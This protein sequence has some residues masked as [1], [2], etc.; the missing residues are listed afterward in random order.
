MTDTPT[1]GTVPIA[2]YIGRAIIVLAVWAFT[3]VQAPLLV[4]AAS[5][6]AVIMGFALLI[7]AVAPCA[8]DRT[9]TLRLIRGSA[10]S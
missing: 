9:T 2:V 4:S 6:L 5:T 1:T 8:A 7:V 3:L 10:L